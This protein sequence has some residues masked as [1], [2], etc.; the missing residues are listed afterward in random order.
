MNDKCI[1]V[2]SII[3]LVVFIVVITMSLMAIGCGLFMSDGFKEILHGS[4]KNVNSDNPGDGWLVLGGI[5]GSVF[6]GFAAALLAAFGIAGVIAAVIFGT[7][8]LVGWII[9]KKTGNRKAYT[10]CFFI[11][12]ALISFCL[13]I[14]YISEFLSCFSMVVI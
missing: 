3:S 7:P 14:T 8:I 2:T 6:G 1:K 5:F 4:V 12:L 11:P 10:I 9:W 13:I